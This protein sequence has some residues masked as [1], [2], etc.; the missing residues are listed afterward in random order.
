MKCSICKQETEKL[1]TRCED[2]KYGIYYS[3]EGICRECANQLLIEKI[4][5]RLNGKAI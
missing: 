1:L 2:V 5:E 3:G 4:K